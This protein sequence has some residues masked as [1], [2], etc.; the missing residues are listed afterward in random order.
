V[1]GF[2]NLPKS[3]LAEMS[4]PPPTAATAS[5]GTTA[6]PRPF[7]AAA[8]ASTPACRKARWASRALRLTSVPAAIART[9]CAATSRARV[10][11]RAAPGL[12]RKA[13]ASNGLWVRTRRMIAAFFSATA[14]VPAWTA[15]TQSAAA[16]SVRHRLGAAI[17]LIRA[18]RTSLEGR[19]ASTVV[20]AK[21][22]SVSIT[23]PRWD[24]VCNRRGA[25]A[26]S[27]QRG[28]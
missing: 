26:P 1:G 14:T 2:E 9:A 5:L 10:L 18:L 19:A 4:A 24:S 20:N 27:A 25:D 7:R 21:A 13:P 8:S 12:G 3:R 22:V 28:R 16:T 23:C 15:A 11:A 6:T 17:I